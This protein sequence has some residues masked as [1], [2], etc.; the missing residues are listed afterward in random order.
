MDQAFTK[1]FHLIESLTMSDQPHGITDLA[2]ELT[3]TKS[4]VH[5]LLMT[6]Q[7]QGYVRQIPPH[8]TY[9]LTTK[10]RRSTATSFTAR[11]SLQSQDL[12]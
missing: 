5:R 1:G 9:E 8:S 12:R 6:L 2:N 7:G 3:P 10:I 11:T 4:N